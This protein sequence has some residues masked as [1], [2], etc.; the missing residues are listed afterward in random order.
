MK[1][2]NNSLEAIFEDH[3]Y[4]TDQPILTALHLV[5]SL[6]KPLLVEGPAG[7]GKTEIAKVLAKSLNTKLIR[8]QCYEGLDVN[9][10]L[11]EWNYAKQML[12]IRLT[13]NSEASLEKREE[14]IFGK[15]FL[16]T[17]PILEAF[18]E[19]EA[20]P[21]LLIDEVDRADEAFEAFLLEALAEFQITIPE[22]GTIKAKHRPYVILTSNRTRELSDALR[23]RCLYQWVSYPD[24]K[25]ETEILQARLPE[26]D[27]SLA[28][29]IAKLMERI[30]QM[31]LQKIPGVAESLDWAQALISMHRSELN[32]ET[33]QETLGCFLKNQDDWDTVDK[34]LQ[35][36]TLLR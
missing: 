11:Y 35:Q 27:K 6:Q 9:N 1:E 31:P 32:K 10:A 16:L 29:Q 18:M 33:I 13:E 30:R 14:D 34:E 23:R 25:K 15:E 24:F 21:V 20:P 3:G 26:I 2:H 17:R 28:I 5:K 7:V 8:L 36:G 22:L 4:I 19:E 12:H